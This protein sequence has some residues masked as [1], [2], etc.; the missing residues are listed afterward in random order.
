M[1]SF[2]G[3]SPPTHWNLPSFSS[4]LFSLT[5]RNSTLFCSPCLSHGCRELKAVTQ[6]AV[7]LRKPHDTKKPRGPRGLHNPTSHLNSCHLLNV[8]S[9]MK[10]LP[11]L[12]L[13]QPMQPLPMT[14]SSRQVLESGQ[15]NVKHWGGKAQKI[16]IGAYGRIDSAA[17]DSSKISS[18]QWH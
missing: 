3:R 14:H 1:V 6:R 7:K 13:T 15:D 18:Q 10:S 4:F 2:S 5:Q 8:H 11:S 17:Y 9:V 16:E 12:N